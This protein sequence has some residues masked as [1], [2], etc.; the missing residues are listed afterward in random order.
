MKCYNIYSTHTY[1]P[2]HRNI[3]ESLTQAIENN[4]TVLV[5]NE[6]L[7]HE[8]AGDLFLN[9]ITLD[10]RLVERGKPHRFEVEEDSEYEEDIN[11]MLITSHLGSFILKYMKCNAEKKTFLTIK[12]HMGLT[13]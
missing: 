11:V 3:E 6:K 10:V 13:V 4:S 1:I 12:K 2:T 8:I 5:D 7:Y 9:N